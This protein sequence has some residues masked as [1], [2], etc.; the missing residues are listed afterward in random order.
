M[1]AALTPDERAAQAAERLR[2]NQ[3]ARDRRAKADAARAAG[4]GG[5]GAAGAGD[6]ASDG[7]DL[8]GLTTEQKVAPAL[9]VASRRV[10]RARR[11]VEKCAAVADVSR[12]WRR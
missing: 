3:E 4:G 1:S 7:P 11:V 2:R 9:C 6:A 10:G 12:R 5:G 8:A